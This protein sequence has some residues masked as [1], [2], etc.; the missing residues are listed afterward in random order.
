MTYSVLHK[1]SAQCRSCTVW[2]VHAIVLTLVIFTP[3][4]ATGEVM[5]P[6][7]P[8]L[9]QCLHMWVQEGESVRAV[10]GAVG[11]LTPRAAAPIPSP[12]PVRGAMPVRERAGHGLVCAGGVD[13]RWGN[14]VWPGR[15]VLA[16]KRPAALDALHF[17]RHL[18][19]TCQRM[20]SSRQNGG[21]DQSQ[22]VPG[23]LGPGLHFSTHLP[24]L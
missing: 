22:A 19:V 13:R 6:R 12:G 8:E 7:W 17:L 20:R 3:I 4:P 9:C 5:H 21:T 1:T 11:A 15:Q 10:H 18:C 14:V 24:S 2:Q 23:P 16:V